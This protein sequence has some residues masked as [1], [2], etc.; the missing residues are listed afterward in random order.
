MNVWRTSWLR[1]LGKRRTDV[2]RVGGPEEEKNGID[3][4]E[5]TTFVLV[6]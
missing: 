6:N 3:H 2:K 5:F 4:R 1:G